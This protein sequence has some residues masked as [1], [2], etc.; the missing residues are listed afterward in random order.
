ME[1]LKSLF[2]I[3]IKTYDKH[4][5]ELSIELN[6]ELENS[7]LFLNGRCEIVGVVQTLRGYHIVGFNILKFVHN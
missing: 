1:K 7:G 3:S 2:H 4:R 6:F 5:Y